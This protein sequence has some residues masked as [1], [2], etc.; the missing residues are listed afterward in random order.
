LTV[1][2]SAY[3]LSLLTALLTVGSLSDYIGRR[4][5]I[6]AA[7]ILN[8]LAMFMFVEAHSAV[9]LTAARI[10]QGFATGTATTTIGAA[11]LDTNRAHGPL[12]NSITTFIGL[13][14]GV[15]GAG[16]LVTF[17]PDPTQLVYLVLMAAS[18][19]EALVLWQMPETVEARSGALA[20]LRPQVSVPRQARATLLRL[21]PLNI[22]L[23]ALGGFNFSLMPSVVRVAT[24]LTSPMI[25]GMVVATLSLSGTVAVV[26]MRRQPAD[27]ILTVGTAA[28][29][30]GVAT[31]LAGVRLQLVPLM[32]I[33]MAI[34]GFGF[35]SAF[36]GILR[37][38]LPLAA[39]SERAGLLAAFYVE[40]YLA[41][42]LPAVAVGLVAPVL[43]LPLSTY[44]YGSA[45]VVLALTSFIAMR[46]AT[47][48]SSAA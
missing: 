24:G 31:T 2:F 33:G 36:S 7:L 41:F 29:A 19:A 10:V 14:I 6:F 43:G 20:S 1:I 18:L 4:P 40:S 47:A 34:A 5:V 37:T 30:V 12:L 48:T 22:A 46:R 44:I 45:I 15:L 27:R 32:L 25:G 26:L 38:V 3:V 13:T 35:G 8:A 42:S 39:A 17:A 9:A 23:W 16:A 21:T 11:I 28:L